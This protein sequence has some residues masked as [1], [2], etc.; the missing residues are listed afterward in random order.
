M[1]DGA[2]FAL[3]EVSEKE[4]EALVMDALATLPPLGGAQA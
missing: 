3:L 1:P 4:C 2:I